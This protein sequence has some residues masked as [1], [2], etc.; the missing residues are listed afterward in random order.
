MK[1]YQYEFDK[2]KIKNKIMKTVIPIF[3]LSVLLIGF[4]PIAEGNNLR[5]TNVAVNQ[6][7]KIVTFDIS[8]DNSW[9][10]AGA[11]TNWDAIWVFVKF[12]DCAA[13]AATAFTHGALSATKANHTFGASLEPMTTP[14]T[15]ST[16]GCGGADV[17]GSAVQGAT[18]D[19]TEGVLLRRSA[20]GSGILQI[21]QQQ[22]PL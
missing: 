16:G 22:E 8:W 11:P 14:C 12:R 18:L 21:F 2:L 15:A 13:T 17:T 6:T 7:T 20:V 5:I 1:S 4:N 19:F 10:L 9:R 3:L